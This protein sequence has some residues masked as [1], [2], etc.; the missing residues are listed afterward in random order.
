[1]LPFYEFISAGAGA[2]KSMLIRCLNESLIRYFDKIHGANPDME[3]VLWAAPTGKAAYI[4]G[5]LTLHSAFSL[6]VNQFSGEMSDLSANVCNTL[7][8]RLIQLKLQIIDEGSMVGSKMLKQL[9]ESLRQIMDSNQH[10]GGVSIIC[11][12]DFHQLKPVGDR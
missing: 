1:M 6:P 5:G 9:N 12:G 8:N 4:I 2:G 7:R 11:V 10:F 3:K